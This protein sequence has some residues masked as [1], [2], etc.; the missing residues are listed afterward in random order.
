MTS[1]RSPG[2]FRQKSMNWTAR[3]LG[4]GISPRNIRRIARQTQSFSVSVYSILHISFSFPWLMV[5]LVRVFSY[6]LIDCA[7]RGAEISIPS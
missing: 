6:L 2:V 3:G 5:Y 4:C 7:H 1:L